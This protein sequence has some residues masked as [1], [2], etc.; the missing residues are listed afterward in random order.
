MGLARRVAGRADRSLFRPRDD[1]R[2]RAAEP[3][4]GAGHAARIRPHQRQHYRIR[5]RPCRIQLGRGQTVSA[6]RPGWCG[7]PSRSP[8]RRV[9]E[10]TAA[11]HRSVDNDRV[12]RGRRD[13][14]LRSGRC[15]RLPGV[16]R[17]LRGTRNQARERPGFHRRRHTRTTRSGD[18]QPGIRAACHARWRSGWTPLPNGNHALRAGGWCG[19]R[20]KVPRT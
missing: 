3:E 15:A 14:S 6:A 9:R 19:G 1:V 4:N 12:P 10:F 2:G 20:R 16:A 5:S 11:Q 18:R 7:G 13:T 8:G 17:L